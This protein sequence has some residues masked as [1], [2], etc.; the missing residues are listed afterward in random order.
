MKRKSN[1]YPNLSRF[2]YRLLTH[3]HHQGRQVGEARRSATAGGLLSRAPAASSTS[4]PSSAATAAA[5][6]PP[7]AWG[8]APP[9]APPWGPL[10]AG[11][12]AWAAALVAAYRRPRGPEMQ[13]TRALDL[14][15]TTTTTTTV[16]GINT[17]RRGRA[18]FRSLRCRR[19]PGTGAAL[20]SC[21]WRSWGEE[22]G[23]RAAAAAGAPQRGDARRPPR[24]R[25]SKH[26]SMS[27]GLCR[28]RRRHEGAPMPM[29]MPL[30][31][32]CCRRS[33]HQARPA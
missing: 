25:P 13:G 33:R 3:N 18:F 19:Y 28:C 23:L 6:G 14:L 31:G 22:A 8:L 27:A 17:T 9:S 30:R 11:A 1:T 7:W 4:A 16:T 26:F 20:R 29:L 15:G 5:W 24:H 32:P 21:R 12:A 10:S 2:R